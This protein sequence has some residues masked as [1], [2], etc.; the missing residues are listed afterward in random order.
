MDPHQP[1]QQHLVP[2]NGIPEEISFGAMD[3]DSSSRATPVQTIKKGAAKSARSLTKKR[4]TPAVKKKT[5]IA[6]LISETAASLG[7]QAVAATR[8][9]IEDG[10]NTFSAADDNNLIFNDEQQEFLWRIEE[11]KDNGEV[12]ETKI[13][14][15]VE[16]TESKDSP[17]EVIDGTPKEEDEAVDTP[18]DTV[19]PDSNIA[20]VDQ[21]DNDLVDI[22]LEDDSLSTTTS[23][24]SLRSSGSKRSFLEN[25]DRKMHPRWINNLV[26]GTPRLR[27]RLG[28]NNKKSS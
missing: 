4:L 5:S 17:L 21:S 18:Q 14:E 8:A 7:E 3:I 20:L 6:S 25:D 11:S 2:S 28:G 12:E 26:E 16:F 27:R 22:S 24:Y 23:Q 9:L 10:I 1:V 19:H 13:S 15:D